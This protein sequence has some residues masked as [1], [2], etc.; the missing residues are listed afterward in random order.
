MLEAANWEFGARRPTDQAE[1]ALSSGTTSSFRAAGGLLNVVRR[2]FYSKLDGAIH[3]WLSL[4]SGSVAGSTDGR[5]RGVPGSTARNVKNLPTSQNQST[6]RT[7]ADD[8]L[9]STVT[10]HYEVDSGDGCPESMV[11]TSARGMKIPLA[12]TPVQP[13]HDVL[14]AMKERMASGK[15]WK[16]SLNPPPELAAAL[17]E[18][19][20]GME[21]SVS[22]DNVDE[23]SS[24]ATYT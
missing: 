24:Q 4:F 2:A 1:K 15:R 8:E 17:R 3:R 13:P 16:G 5:N 23:E 12:L 14:V 20:M 19:S 11:E 9:N 6:E 22:R 18:A 21:S 7:L 10:T